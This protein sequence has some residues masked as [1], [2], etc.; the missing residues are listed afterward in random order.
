MK[1]LPKQKNAVYYL[2]DTATGEI[3]FGGGAW[4]VVVN[5]NSVFYGWLNRAKSIPVLV[6]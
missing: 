6:G 5:Q 1:L 4:L 3:L 2:K